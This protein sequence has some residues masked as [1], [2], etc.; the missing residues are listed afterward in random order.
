MD[1]VLGNDSTLRRLL[2]LTKN[3]LGAALLF[4]LA[5]LIQDYVSNDLSKPE[6]GAPKA[7]MAGTVV[8]ASV[9]GSA[10]VP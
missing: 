7:S 8:S 2:V 1:L 9:A 4:T 5:V 6:A 3:V 10:Y